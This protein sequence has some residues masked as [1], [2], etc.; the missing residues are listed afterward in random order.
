MEN[1]DLQKILKTG[2]SLTI[3]H[4]IVDI[5]GCIVLEANQKVS[6]REVGL[7]PAGWSS[8]YSMYIPEKYIWVKLEDIYGIWKFST[9]VETRSLQ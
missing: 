1:N 9:F 8:F 3:A 4:D 7:R 6:I 2:N 5:S